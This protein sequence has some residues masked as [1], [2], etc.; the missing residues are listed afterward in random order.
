VQYVNMGGVASHAFK[1]VNFAVSVGDA[2]YPINLKRCLSCCAKGIMY[3]NVDVVPHSPLVSPNLNNT[4]N[5][6]GSYQHKYD[7]HFVINQPLV[8][9]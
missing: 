5:L 2:L 9:L 8:D 3:R 1:E 7:P 4:F 6:F